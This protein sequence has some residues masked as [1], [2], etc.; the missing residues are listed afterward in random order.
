MN[1]QQRDASSNLVEAVH[2][3]ATRRFWLPITMAFVM[4]ASVFFGSSAPFSV[5]NVEIQCGETAPDVRF[6]P[7]ATEVESFLE[8]CGKQ[9]RT[10]YRNMQRAD[11]L[12]PLSLGLFL[13]SSLTA[14]LRRLFAHRRAVAAFA[15]IGLL[16]TLFDYLENIF[17]WR[18]L[19]V[20]PSAAATTPLFGAASAA[21]T[22]T[23]WLTGLTLL[24]AVIAAGAQVMTQKIRERRDGRTT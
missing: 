11:L 6:A 15:A 23:F 1:K 20:Y 8:T 22:A 13:T 5:G 18:A 3:L 17:A 4:F 21:K 16:G 14:V 2:R 19:S 9:G 12:Y 24:F 7:S 10:A